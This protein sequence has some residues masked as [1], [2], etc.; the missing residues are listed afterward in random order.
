MSLPAQYFDSLYGKS[1]DPWGFETRWYEERKRAVTLAMLPER[2]YGRV[3]EPGCSIGTLT[4]ELAPRCRF[5]LATDSAAEAV[6]A[7][8][9]ACRQHSHVVIEQATI[10]DDW[11]PADFD[12]VVLS[13]I[14][15]YFGEAD[16]ARLLMLAFRDARTVLAVHWRHPV[17]D[18][19]MTGDA[20]HE[21]MNSF[22]AHRGFR[23][24]AHYL[25]DDF[26]ATLWTR[27]RRSVAA[28][29]G[30]S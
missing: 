11:P 15:Y 8:R 27:D 18:Y 14:A 16:L 12:L 13:E 26:Q 22:A 29:E 7:A 5:L 30:L 10:P 17:A 23:L 4:R 3:Y 2:S 9:V 6:R 21:V 24:A 1:P 20:T 28:R 25:D 19:P